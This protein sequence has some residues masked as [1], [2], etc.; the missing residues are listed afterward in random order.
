M[1]PTLHM[2]GLA[3]LPSIEAEPVWACAYT[4]KM[5]K[6]ARMMKARG[7]PVI[8]YGVEGSQVDC[9]EFVPCLSEEERAGQYGPLSRFAEDHFKYGP[10]DQAYQTFTRNAIEEINGRVQPGDIL[11]NPMGNFYEDLCKGVEKAHGIPFLVEGGIGY[12]GVMRDTHKVFESNTWRSFIYGK[13]GV[14]NAHFYDMVIP[15]FF[16][17]A[18]YKYSEEKEDYYLM[19]CRQAW[20][21]GLQIAFQTTK[22]IG[23]KL[24]IAGQPSEETK[25]YPSHV[26]FL[27]YIDEKE[28]VDLLSHAKALFQPTL[29]NAPFEGVTIEA[30]MSGTPVITTDQGCFTETVLPC[31]TGYRCNVLKEFVKAAKDVESIEPAYCR[32]WTI[33]NYSPE[34]CARKYD[35]YFQR[36]GDLFKKGWGELN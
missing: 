14:E 35:A 28:K 33:A 30:G 13:Y 4:Q 5:V 20:R 10:E 18:H 15:N 1:K 25:V 34:V 36:L 3:H 24:I 17:P 7:Y 23:A 31:L 9:D 6:M 27:G 22:A 26:E 21:K 32:E 29:Y 12:S 2:L 11:I 8:F 19:I 16:D